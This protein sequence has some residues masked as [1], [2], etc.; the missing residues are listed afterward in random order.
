MYQ[1]GRPRGTGHID[2]A[3][4][5]GVVAAVESAA[6]EPIDLLGRKLRVHFSHGNIIRK[7]VA[8]HERLHFSGCTGDES[9]IRT[10]FQQF[11]NSILDIYLCKLF[12]L[13]DSV[14]TTHTE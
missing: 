9:K 11:S 5:D 6:K 1:D 7:P 8:P 2:Y 13:F 12:T 3:S 14:P 10:I 4:M